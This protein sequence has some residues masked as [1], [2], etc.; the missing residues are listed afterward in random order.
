[1]L[2]RIKIS[3]GL[4][5]PQ[6]R[7]IL[8]VCMV[9][10]L[11]F[12]LLIKLSGRYTAEKSVSLQ[13]ELPEDR[14]F[15]QGPPPP[16]RVEVE[17]TGWDLLFSY[18]G[19]KDTIQ[20]NLR[21]SG[22]NRLSTDR[23]QNDI[24]THFATEDLRVQHVYDGNLNLTLEE[25]LVRQLPIRLND[26]LQFAPGY[27]L[28]RPIELT[29]DSV[30]LRGPVS[31]VSRLNRWPTQSLRLQNVKTSQ[32]R[33]VRLQD[34]PPG[35]TLEPT[36]V[37]A[38]IEVEQ[39]TEK[40]LF[41][42]LQVQNAP[43]NDSLRFFPQRVK[44]R[45]IVGLSHYD[46]VDSTGFTLVADLEKVRLGEGQ[47]TVPIQ[48]TERPAFVRSIKFSPEAAQFYIVKRDSISPLQ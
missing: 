18:F 27:Q 9:I 10:S 16:V 22:D 37:Q 45:C 28:V 48:L 32:V 3:K 7:T 14:A 26:S 30:T 13:V 5:L 40:S 42:S 23:L 19:S 43:P 34:P 1:M 12:W 20:Y 35:L 39:L 17:G 21:Q 36:T 41:V 25:T 47:N 29:P 31:E 46:D 38:D 44:V 33:E 11:F 15:S 6:D 4:A 2:P 8:L 24:N